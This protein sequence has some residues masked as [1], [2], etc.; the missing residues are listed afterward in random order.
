MKECGQYHS[1]LKM[2]VGFFEVNEEVEVQV[3]DFATV[4]AVDGMVKEEGQANIG[5]MVWKV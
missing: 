4:E 2:V 5:L 1:G 3:R